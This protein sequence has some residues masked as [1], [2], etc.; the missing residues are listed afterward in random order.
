MKVAVNDFV[1]RQVAGSGKTYSP[2]LSFEEIVQHALEQMEA[3]HFR[4]GYREGVSI[5]DVDHSLVKHFVCPFVRI[6][7]SI[8]L[9]A[10]VVRRRESEEPYIRMRAANGEA[11]PAGKVE[12]I[13]YR[14]DVLMENDEQS[15]DADWELIS[16]NAVPE[17]VDHLPMKPVTMM[18]NQLK[19][20][21]GTSAHYTSKEWA[22]AIKFWQEFVPID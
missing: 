7:E 2:D 10:Q 3:G 18:R 22:Q 15:T 5:V 16:I 21:G 12:L 19:L 4:E 6:D 11:L 14:H 20:S 8:K 1:R 9:I 13:L 17:G